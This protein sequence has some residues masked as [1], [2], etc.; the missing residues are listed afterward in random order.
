MPVT[1]ERRM[2]PR[3]YRG[4]KWILRQLPSP[5]CRRFM[6][7]G[8]SGQRGCKLKDK[9]R[10]Y[11]PVLC[12]NALTMNKCLNESCKL[13]HIRGC[14]RINSPRDT[15][16]KSKESK[17]DHSRK[18]SSNSVSDSRSRSPSGSRKQGPPLGT[19]K[20]RVRYDSTCSTQS[21]NPGS[22][23]KEDFLKH[24]AQMKA[25][26]TSEV[27]KDL[28]NLI[29]TSFREMMNFHQRPNF[30]TASGP[31]QTYPPPPQFR[32]MQYLPGYHPQNQ[33]LFAPRLPQTV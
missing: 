24:L 25:D 6:Q 14:L 29:Q 8:P 23:K 5:W 26:L 19:D 12:R 9:C 22:M 17:T 28:T 11:H 4:F 30:Q 10:Y 7:N 31:G 3:H 15:Q 32:T 21:N 2:P 27:T 20:K 13:T 16:L 18:R 33:T 1:Q